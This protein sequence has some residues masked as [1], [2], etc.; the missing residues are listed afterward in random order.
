MTICSTFSWAQQ[1]AP[2]K[3]QSLPPM[4]TAIEPR[5][6][7]LSGIRLGADIIG[8]GESL[9]DD[10]V[11]KWYLYGDIM[12]DNALFFTLEYG[13]QDITRSGEFTLTEDDTRRYVYQ[14]DGFFW[15]GGVEY[16]LLAKEST[17]S[18]LY[19][20]AKYAFAQFDQYSSYLSQGSDYWE[21][22]SEQQ[23][24][25]EENVNAHWVQ[26]MAGIKYRILGN[27][28]VDLSTALGVPLNFTDDLITANDIPG[29]GLNK[30]NN[31]KMILQMR[32][33]YKIP[34]WKT[35][36]DI[37]EEQLLERY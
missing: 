24:L 27:F 32:L 28:Y 9:F 19:I 16:N 12:L 25:R 11:E 36:V 13:L 14:S 21:E 10:K 29:F 17:Y 5:P 15:R 33:L 30:Q 23:E 7:K 37:T 18:G 8:I 31:S 1:K 34:L 4:V 22:P 3:E 26:V 35:K 6:F 2:E 20:G